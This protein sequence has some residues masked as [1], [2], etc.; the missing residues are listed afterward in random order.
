MTAETIAS[1]TSP[2]TAT[3]PR[4]G[5]AGGALEPAPLG[6]QRAAGGADADR[7]QHGGAR[8]AGPGLRRLRHARPD[9]GAVA[10]R[11]PG[12]HQPDGHRRAPSAGRLPAGDARPRRRAD[13][14]RPLDDL[15]PAQRLHG[16]HAG[17]PRG[18][19]RR[20]LRQPL[21]LGGHRRSGLLGRGARDLRGGAARPGDEALRPRRA[22]PRAAEDHPRQ[23]PSARTRRSAISTP[24]PPATTSAGGRCWR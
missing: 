15:R 24:R 23:R 21:P 4:S 1:R 14:Q 16:G 17:L 20:L 3:D 18:P 12:A 5:D 22:E 8:V 2:V 10:D 7:L 9:D 6:R 19:D 13:H 11:H